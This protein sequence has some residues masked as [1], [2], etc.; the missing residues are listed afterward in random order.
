MGSEA[1]TQSPLQH[2]PRPLTFVLSGGGA[3]GATQVGMIRALRQAGIDPDMVVGTSVGALNGTLLA[4]NPILAVDRLTKIWNSLTESGVFG[5]RSRF[6]AALSAIRNGLKVHN[7]GL[8]S[9]EALQRLIDTHLPVSAIEELSVPTGIVVTDALVGTPKVLSRGP[10]S[11]ALRASAAIPG[12]FPPVGIDGCFYVDGGVSANVPIRQA[13]AFGAK[14]IVVL[15]ANPGSMPGTLPDSV[16]G[17]IVHA[18]AIML[19]NQRADAVEDLVGKYPILK[20]PPST[21]PTKNSFD[22]EDSEALIETGFDVTRDFLRQLPDLTDTS[23]TRAERTEE[24]PPPAPEPLTPEQ[25]DGE[26]RDNTG[27]QTR[28][29]L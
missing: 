9:P 3:Y 6:G 19:R 14:S 8:V 18:S 5:G 4:A 27:P 15:D 23:P 7:P 1:Q 22:F 29:R 10:I 16:I 11:P 21:P 24:P 28:L 2:W 12:V 26:D 20:L 17:S 25:T 13:V